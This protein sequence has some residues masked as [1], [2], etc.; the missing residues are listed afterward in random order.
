VIEAV[1]CR[2]P[3]TSR[4]VKNNLSSHFRRLLG[5]FPGALFFHV[6]Y[7]YVDE[8]SSVL[9]HLKLAAESEAPPRFTFKGI[10]KDMEQLTDSRPRGFI[11]E[12]EGPL[13]PLK[14]VF[15]ALDMRQFAQREAAKTAGQPLTK[16][17][18]KRK[19]AR[20]K[21]GRKNAQG[22]RRPSRTR[23]AIS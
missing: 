6:T 22:R 19:T 7:S 14:V 17:G 3:V 1:V 12:Y 9:R 5:Y 8:P 4:S 16:S 20:T 13:G 21:R 11:A 10:I 2:D 23:S 18:T 15:L